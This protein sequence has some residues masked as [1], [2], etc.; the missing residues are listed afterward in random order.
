MLYEEA[1]LDV[2][3]RAR[4]NGVSGGRGAAGGR[5]KG[6]GCGMLLPRLG[7]FGQVGDC[8]RQEPNTNIEVSRFHR[9]VFKPSRLDAIKK[10]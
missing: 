5:G 6:L 1:G 7:W 10:N 3:G 9:L 4:T 2:P 8:T